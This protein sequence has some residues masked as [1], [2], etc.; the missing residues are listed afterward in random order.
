MRSRITLTLVF[1]GLLAFALVRHGVTN[2]PE[3]PVLAGPA[4]GGPPQPG[5]LPDLWISGLDCDADTAIQI[6]KYNDD[7]YILRQS[8]CD[9]FEAP[10]M[11]LFFGEDAA[12][13]MDTGS[14]PLSPVAE[15]VERVMKQRARDLGGLTRDG[16]MPLIVAHTHSHGDHF[17]GDAQFADKPYV[18]TVVG[19][20]QAQV[21]QFWG[22]QDYPNDIVT[23]ELGNR[24]IDVIA[25]PG[26]QAQSVTLYDHN[27]QILFTGDIVYPGHL[28][29]FSPAEWFDFK[30]SIDR[31]VQFAI[32]HPIEH[33]LGCHIEMSPEPGGSYAWGTPVHPTEHL[34]QFDASILLDIQDAANLM[35]DDPECTIFD[36]FV[37][38]PVYKCGITWN[39]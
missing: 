6:H 3:R 31:L 33:V 20:G 8:K 29:V 14:A 9:T 39:G 2:A 28:F 34:L 17:Q 30:D 37:I 21:E 23:F 4:E 22:F 19:L 25:T 15:A 7:L 18:R 10:F 26:H 11:Y 24:T 16:L 13:L 35:G 27:T 12:L 38:H 1:A 5:V 36:E 32:D